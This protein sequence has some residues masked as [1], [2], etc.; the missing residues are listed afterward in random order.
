MFS[1]IGYRRSLLCVWVVLFSMISYYAA[2]AT[3]GLQAWAYLGVASFVQTSLLIFPL[4]ILGRIADK[5]GKSSVGLIFHLSALGLIALIFSNYKLHSMYN[6]FV[7]GFVINL[8]TTPGGIEALGLSKSFYISASIGG[9]ILAAIY[10]L[11]VAFVPLELAYRYIPAPR[12]MFILASI[13]FVVESSVFAFA[14]YTSN[15]SILPVSSRIVW[16]IPVTARGTF[17]KMGFESNA[18]NDMIDVSSNRSGQL[19]YPA[20]NLD[21]YGVT[22]PYNIVW[23]TAESLR[24]DMVDERIMPNT[25]QFAENQQWFKSHYSGG[26]G[27]RLGMFSQFYGVYGSYWFDFLQNRIPPVLITALQDYGYNM[28]AFTSA[29]FTYPEFKKTIFSTLEDDQLQEYRKGKGWERD[30]KNTE[31]VISFIGENMHKDKPFFT[32]MFFES[33]HA[34]YYFPDEAVIEEDYLDDFDYLSVDIEA[35]IKKIKNRYVNSSH[36][37]DSRLG[38]IFDYLRANDLYDNTIVIV[39]GDHGEEFYEKGRWGHN[40]TFVQEQIRVPLIVHM[41][42][43]LAES[44]SNM[45]S[46]L[47]LPATIL[48]ALGYTAPAETYSFGLD[49]FSPEYQRNYTVASDWHGNTL[50]TPNVK[51]VLTLKGSRNSM[52]LSSLTDREIDPDDIESVDRNKLGHFVRELSRFYN[53]SPEH[54]IVDSNYRATM[55]KTVDQSAS[56][57]LH[58]AMSTKIESIISEQNLSPDI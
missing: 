56:E 9:V 10:T 22:K 57:N 15:V 11:F 27:T 24:H 51:Y 38:K 16:H 20:V 49:L 30:R 33:A 31:D 18:S 58:L 36:Y 12:K 32:F 21:Q 41:P 43:K 44:Y 35:N 46:H 3:T 52:K 37:L 17:E 8:L 19:A 29:R 1:K 6:F 7:D 39:T 23:L 53:G 47:D 13:G 54:K 34:N 45:T 4:F 40:S 42:D 14:S 48:G 5:T 26:N 50:I 28:K 55:S 25:H 2:I